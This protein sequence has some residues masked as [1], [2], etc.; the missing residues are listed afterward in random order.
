MDAGQGS[1]LPDFQ[2][3]V[4]SAASEGRSWPRWLGPKSNAARPGT[5]PAASRQPAS[6]PFKFEQRQLSRPKP[7]T[8]AHCYLLCL[9]NNRITFLQTVFTCISPQGMTLTCHIPTAAFGVFFVIKNKKKT[10]ET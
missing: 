9:C 3:A 6:Q 10:E 7:I 8:Q 1:F 4:H 5:Q 2:R